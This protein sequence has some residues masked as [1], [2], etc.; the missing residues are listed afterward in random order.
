MY[1]AEVALRALV[2]VY[3]RWYEAEPAVLLRVYVQYEQWYCARRRRIVR[4]RRLTC[5]PTSETSGPISTRRFSESSVSNGHCSAIT[6]W[7]PHGSRSVLVCCSTGM[8]LRV[9]RSS[10]VLRSPGAY[11]S[12]SLV[13]VCRYAY[14]GVSPTSVSSVIV[15]IPAR[16]IVITCPSRSGP[17]PPISV[18]PSAHR[19][20]DSTSCK[21][22]AR[23]QYRTSH[24]QFYCTPV[25][26]T[27]LAP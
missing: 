20:P 4:H 10:M 17:R 26:D 24:Y 18:C 19:V 9:P 15:L 23:H 5:N 14:C 13:L 1:R 7:Y 22:Y 21:P 27:N 12:P 16:S 25:A 2:L 11:Y 3:V 8:L 6:A